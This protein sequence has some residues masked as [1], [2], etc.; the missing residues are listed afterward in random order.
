MKGV[1]RDEAAAFAHGGPDKRQS[2]CVC[3]VTQVNNPRRQENPAGCISAPAQPETRHERT[4]WKTG[5]AT[6]NV[7]PTHILTPGLTAEQVCFGQQQP[8]M[9][10]ETMV[11]VKKRLSRVSNIF[12]SDI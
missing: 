7:E 5:R 12:G 9:V 10:Q 2:Q 1:R 4:R 8:F 3:C 6:A 11:L